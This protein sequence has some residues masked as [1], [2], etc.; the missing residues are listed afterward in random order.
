[1]AASGEILMSL[2]TVE[3]E[4][5]EVVLFQPVRKRRRQQ[6]ELVALWGDEVVGHGS[7]VAIAPGRLVALAP[8]LPG[9][10]QIVPGGFVQQAQ[11]YVILTIR[12]SH[13]HEGRRSDSP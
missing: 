1:M 8:A 7:L 13:C 3:D 9:T 5:G 12:Y 2:D 11:R 6:V 10:S 4:P